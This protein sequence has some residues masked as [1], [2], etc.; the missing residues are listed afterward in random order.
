[1]GHMGVHYYSVCPSTVEP[2]F[3]AQYRKGQDARNLEMQNHKLDS[4]ISDL[5]QKI[6][7]SYDSYEQREITSEMEQLK[8]LRAKNEHDL[9][10]IV[11]KKSID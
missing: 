9:Q 10:Q 1:M 8:Q 7:R 2:P 5:A 4:K 6:L 11:P 3:L